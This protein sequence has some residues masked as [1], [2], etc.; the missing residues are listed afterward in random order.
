MFVKGQSGNPLGRRLHSTKSPTTLVQRSVRKCVEKYLTGDK[1][2]KDLNSLDPKSRTQAI[3][4]YMEFITPKASQTIEVN[5]TQTTSIELRLKQ[6]ADNVKLPTNVQKIIDVA[7]TQK[8]LE[9]SSE[10]DIDE[11]DEDNDNDKER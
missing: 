6:L 7:D 10:E 4:K 8:Q 2:E 5:K 3:Q 1:L 9:E 11:E